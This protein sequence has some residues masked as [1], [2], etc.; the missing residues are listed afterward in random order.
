MMMNTMQWQWKKQ[1]NDSDNDGD[2]DIDSENTCYV[3]AMP[4]VF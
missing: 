2:N 4:I 3:A 1:W